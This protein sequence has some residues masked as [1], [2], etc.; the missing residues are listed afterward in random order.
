MHTKGLFNANQFDLGQSVPRIYHILGPVYADLMIYFLPA[1]GWKFSILNQISLEGINNVFHFPFLFY[2]FYS[3][4]SWAS[5]SYCW[6][7]PVSMSIRAINSLQSEACVTCGVRKPCYSKTSSG[8][9]CLS[10]SNHICMSWNTAITQNV[11]V[12]VVGRPVAI[13]GSCLLT[14]LMLLS[15]SSVLSS[16]VR[17]CGA[18]RAEELF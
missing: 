13:D 17:I 3:Q 5:K 10:S 1:G 9:M 6:C 11:N 18:F 16:S 4:V 12:L 15:V 7:Q 14:R 2:H 8:S